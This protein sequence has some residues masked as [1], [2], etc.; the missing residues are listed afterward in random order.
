M[1][2]MSWAWLITLS[3]RNP[4]IAL[5]FSE[6]S[7]EKLVNSMHSKRSTQAVSEMERQS[8]AYARPGVSGGG[9]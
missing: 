5:M 6:M 3:K 2:C 4:N 7:I 1:G 9:V 8:K